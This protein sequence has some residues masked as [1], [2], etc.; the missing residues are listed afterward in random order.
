MVKNLEIKN[1]NFSYENN[2]V[3]TNLNL[4]V[5]PHSFH[6]LIGASGVGKTSLLR[7]ISGLEKT[8]ELHSISQIESIGFV[9]QKALFFPWL[10]ILKNLEITTNV[11]E[12]DILSTLERFKLKKFS[13]MYPH[14]LSGGTLQKVNLLRSFIQRSD[15][16]L[17]DEPFTHLD[18]I[19]KEELYQFTLELW[20]DYRPTILLVTHDFDEAIFLAENISYLSKNKKTITD[21]FAVNIKRNIG[22]NEFKLS[23]ERHEYYSKLYHHLKEDLL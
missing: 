20:N 6:A 23:N 8:T 18:L 2:I 17:M 3:L 15:H 4:S 14:Q 19:Q 13:E 1:L 9:F 21:T 12:A 10:N 11:S 16:I 22:F 7:L 5:S